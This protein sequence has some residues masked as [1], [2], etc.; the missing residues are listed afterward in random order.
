MVNGRV[1]T[2]TCLVE[3]VSRGRTVVGSAL[4]EPDL[5]CHSDD[6]VR[7]RN[8]TIKRRMGTLS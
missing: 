6:D 3:G 5:V 7:L 2:G 4:W 1:K 8:R